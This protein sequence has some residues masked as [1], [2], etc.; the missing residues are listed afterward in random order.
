MKRLFSITCILLLILF[1]GCKA[2][3]LTPEQ[4]AKANEYTRMIE[5][6]DFTFIASNAQPMR[7]RTINLTS[8]YSL[9]VTKDT[10]EAYLPYFGRAY[11]APSNPS[12][13]G[14]KFVSTDFDYDSV[15]KKN[16]TYEIKITPN[17]LKKAEQRGTVLYLNI[18]NSGYGSLSVQM[19]NKQSISYYGRLETKK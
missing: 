7:G 15:L 4:Q 19:T 9:R 17:D 10:I 14:I 16:G 12:E 13:G 2:K 11:T 6:P 3:E 8:D 1:V 5:T 18:S